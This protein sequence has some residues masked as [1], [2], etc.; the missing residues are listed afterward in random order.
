MESTKK[1]ALRRSEI[2]QRK[3]QV[4][5]VE[6]VLQL[7]QISNTLLVI[8]HELHKLGF[9]SVCDNSCGKVMFLHLSV[10]L[11][12]GGSAAVHARIHPPG[13]TPPP[14]GQTPVHAGIHPPVGRHPSGRHPSRDGH[15]SGRYISYWNAF[16]YFESLGNENI[17]LFLS[18]NDALLSNLSRRGRMQN[19]VGRVQLKKSLQLVHPGE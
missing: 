17:L 6:S 9:I 13:Q 4:R 19:S 15:C 11:S 16:L 5:P 1:H 2:I 14:P 8:F 18:L 10:I 7:C 12:T 3:T